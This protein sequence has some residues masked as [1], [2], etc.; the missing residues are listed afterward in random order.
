MLAFHHLN[1]SYLI[2]KDKEMTAQELNLKDTERQEKGH[3]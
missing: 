3:V 2:R 1:C